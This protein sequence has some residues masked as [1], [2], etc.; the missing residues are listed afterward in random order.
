MALTSIGYGA[1]NSGLQ[2][3]IINGDVHASF[4]RRGKSTAGPSA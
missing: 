4:H 2:A 3:H 1:N